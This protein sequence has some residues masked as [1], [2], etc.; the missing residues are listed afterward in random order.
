[1]CYLLPNYIAVDVKHSADYCAV[2]GSDF[3]WKFGEQN[4]GQKEKG[5]GGSEWG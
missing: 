1:M 4:D 3:G 5:K 2:D